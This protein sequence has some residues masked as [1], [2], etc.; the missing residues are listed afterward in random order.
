MGKNRILQTGL[1]KVPRVFILICLLVR[2]ALNKVK[3][4][5]FV[6]IVEE[7]MK[8]VIVT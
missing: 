2:N 3:V 4:S 1:K 6:L 5:L 8:I 7:K